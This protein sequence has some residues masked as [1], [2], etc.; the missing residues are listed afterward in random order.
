MSA[1]RKTKNKVYRLAV[2]LLVLIL[3]GSSGY[4]LWKHL[5]YQKGAA[6]YAEAA[7]TAAVPQLKPVPLPEQDKP[8]QKDPN[9]DLLAEVDLDSLREI[10]ED[11]LGW[12][13]IP[14]TVLS[15]PLVQCGDNQYYLNRTWQDKRSAVGAIF[16]ECECA[17]DFSDFNTII[18]GHRMNNESMFGVLHGYKD[19]S[20]W[21]EHPTVYVV[22]DGI[23]RVYDVY[24]ALEPG[25]Q[26]IVYRLKI[27]DREEKQKLI[28][29]GLEHSVIDTGIVPDPEGQ[30]LTLSTCTGRGHA[31]RWVVQAVLREV[32]GS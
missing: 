12:I 4:L 10:N 20:F 25:V 29:F 6:D 27:T 15:Y 26:E 2:L 21:R 28:D 11:V 3:I 32:Q 7:E 14:D 23:V 17:S 24:A 5:D 19:L 1:N 13:V 30:I 22:T 31:T 8:A 9:L 18:Y 16:M